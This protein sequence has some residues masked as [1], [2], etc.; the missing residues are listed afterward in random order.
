MQH[1]IGIDVSKD[2]LDIHRRA[3]DA[4]I[5]LGNDTPGFRRL[6]KWIGPDEAPLIVF[7]ATGAYHRSLEKFL[8]AHDLPFVKVNPKQARR[9]AQAIGKL[10]KTDRVDA[11]MLS[12]MGSALDLQRQAPLD[13][14]QHDLKEMLTARRALIKDQSAAKARLATATVPL[15]RRQL[16]QRLAQI[17]RDVAQIDREMADQTG[18]DTEMAERIGILTSI[19]GVGLLT[20]ITLLVD[21]PELGTLD[22][23]EVAALAGLAPITQR[24]GTW[25]GAARI[26]GGRASVRRA[27][28][29]PTL[30]AARFN[31]DLKAKYTQLIDAGKKQKVALTA[32]MRKLIV[33]ANAL[34][35]GRREWV[36]IIH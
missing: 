10:A 19:P 20:A 13:E 5:Q 36:E 34:L 6:L 9:F 7:E 2:A 28:Y 30:V 26:Q 18:R 24:S 35:R 4:T 21:M 15:I 11:E 23:K 16:R 27:L 32:I 14:S 17:G 31:P 29:M 25:Q 8:T 12:R 22:G 3:D 1:T 33:L